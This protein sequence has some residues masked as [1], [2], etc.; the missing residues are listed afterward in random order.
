M[1]DA[2]PQYNST[3]Q[4]VALAYAPLAA[5]TTEALEERLFEAIV[6]SNLDAS[7]P[8]FS[9]VDE[10]FAGPDEPKSEHE[11][12]CALYSLLCLLSAR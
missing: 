6:D 3:G 5:L 11:R 10:Y 7:D 8:L 4:D 1:N 2:S 9:E 12:R